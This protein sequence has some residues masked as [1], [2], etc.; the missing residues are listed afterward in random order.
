MELGMQRE[1]LAVARKLLK[2]NPM[3]ATT[4]SECVETILIQ[5]DHL[6]PWRR[7]VPLLSCQ[8]IVTMFAFYS[9]KRDVAEQEMFRQLGKRHKQRQ[10][11][12]DRV[13]TK[14]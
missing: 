3:V 4:F 10:D 7:R 9:P 11:E 12:I 14:D 1:C 5:A 8:D 6:E 2:A 13:R